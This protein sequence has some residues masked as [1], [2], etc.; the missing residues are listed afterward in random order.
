MFAMNAEA[1][2]MS[3]AAARAG[4][5]VIVPIL[6]PFSA[7]GEMLNEEALV[8]LVEFL[9]AAGVDGL[10][11]CGTT[12]EWVFLSREERQRV[13]E[14]VLRTAAGRVAV[15]AQTG[16]ASTVETVALTQHA[17][18]LGVQAVT[19]VSPY[20]YRLSDAAL[21]EHYVRVAGSVPGFPVFL[22][23]IPQNTGN[24]LSPETVAQI[25]GRCS[26]VVGIKDSSG[27]VA[28]LIQYR[29]EVGR[30]F[31]ALMGSDRLIL[32]ALANGADGFIPG[33]ANVM[34][35]L[36]V[37]LY[38]AFKSGDWASARHAQEQVAS[39]ARI[40]GDGDLSLFKGVL[41]RRGLPVGPV[42]RPLLEKS[43]E[44]LEA[45]LRQLEA[46]GLG[47]SPL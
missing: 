22:Y 34:P 1:D 31:Y 14:V 30:Q 41:Q 23:N 18:D 27:N 32:A 20:Y 35:E 11:T 5:G 12:G 16:A 28:Q 44:E 9:I 21:V 42:R 19:V 25:T 15:L 46:A 13:T 47:L 33:N 36:F 40:L 2:A 17:R 26:N 39:L 37:T 3:R 45:R 29:V 43:P 24:N 10:I 4:C 6:T 8:R 38:H 7:G